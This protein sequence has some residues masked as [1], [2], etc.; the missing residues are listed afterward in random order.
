[1]TARAQAVEATRTSILDALVELAMTRLFTEIGLDDVAA[2]AGVSVQTVLRHFG[3]RDGL[4]D[5]AMSHAMVSVARSARP[6]R[7]T[8][9]RRCASSSTT[10]RSAAGPA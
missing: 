5:A 2:R 9:P 10:T 1:M 8:S 4:F 7:E 3:T 6:P